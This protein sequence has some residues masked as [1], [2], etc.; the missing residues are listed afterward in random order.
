MERRSFPK[1]SETGICLKCKIGIGRV[2]YF[3]EGKEVVGRRMKGL[4]GTE[5]FISLE[6]VLRKDHHLIW[7]D[8]LPTASE[9]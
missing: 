1:K 6:H 2:G 4:W 7:Q 5:K 9:P 8:N 3:E